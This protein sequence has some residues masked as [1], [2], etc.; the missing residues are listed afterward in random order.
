MRVSVPKEKDS[1]FAKDLFEAI[2][3]NVEELAQEN[4]KLPKKMVFS[5]PLGKEAL[6]FIKAKEWDFGGFILE[7]L[8]GMANLITFK[9]EEPLTVTNDP[10]KVTF[11]QGS[12]HGKII[13]G[14]PGDS[15]VHKLISSYASPNFKVEKTVR[16]ER[17][18]SLI[19]R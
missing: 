10:G 18:V 9:Y 4:L 7:S 6:G 13:N 16:P 2:S 3:K 12:L 5:G 17:R 14:I 19:R 15:T 1:R 11:E 8:G